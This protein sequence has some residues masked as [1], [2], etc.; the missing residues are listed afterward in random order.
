MFD[1]MKSFGEVMSAD[2]TKDSFLIKKFILSFWSNG[3]CKFTSMKWAAV[4]K[5]IN[6][7]LKCFYVYTG[8]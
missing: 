7:V 5:K 4:L 1:A 8:I 3:A 6:W 2:T